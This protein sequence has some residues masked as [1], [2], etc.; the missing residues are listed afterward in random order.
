[1][2]AWR[3]AGIRHFRLEFAHES[4]AQVTRVTSAFEE[5]LAGR[6]T[7]RELAQALQRAAPAGITE[8]SLYVPEGYRE[9]VV[10]E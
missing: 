5:A 7:P 9:L 10:L 8:G 1:M 3:A 2:P 4:A 6:H